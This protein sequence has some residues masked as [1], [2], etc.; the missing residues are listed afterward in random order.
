MVST[1]VRHQ[2]GRIWPTDPSNAAAEG[3]IATISNAFRTKPARILCASFNATG[4]LLVTL[5]THGVLVAFNLEQN[6][7]AVVSHAGSKCVAIAFSA[8]RRCELYVSQA[9]GAVACIDLT[10]KVTIGSMKGHIHPVRWLACHPSRPLLASTAADAL[11]VWNTRDFSRVRAMPTGRQAQLL[12]AVF[13]PLGEGLLTCAES[14]ITLWRLGSFEAALVLRVPTAQGAAFKLRTV[15][16]TADGALAAGACE[17]GWLALW[18][19]R[20]G[21]LAKMILLPDATATVRELTPLP[22]AHGSAAA[23]GSAPSRRGGHHASFVLTGEDGK[24]RVLDAAEPAIMQTLAPPAPSGRFLGAAID[25]A[26]KY[27]CAI[28]ADGALILYGM[29]ALLPTSS[30]GG[31]AG[32]QSSPQRLRSVSSGPLFHDNEKNDA[33]QQAAGP[34][35][36]RPLGARVAP[37]PLPSKLQAGWERQALE[38]QGRA[39]AEDSPLAS[40]CGV[41]IGSPLLD[42]RHLRTM[43]RT[44]WIF[45]APQRL[46]AWRFALQLPGN[47]GAHRALLAKGAHS[48][49]KQLVASL[50]LADRR[51]LRRLERLLS[52][53]AH[54]CPLLGLVRELPPAVY[55]L[56]LAFG[57]DDLA[58]FEASATVLLN[59]GA[60]FYEFHPHPPVEV[61]RDADRLLVIHA[62]AVHAHLAALGCGADVW[63]WPLLASLFSR[64]LAK[65]DW[66]QLWDHLLCNEPRFLLFVLVT[67]VALHGSLLCATASVASVAAVLVSRPAAMLM[68]VWLQTAYELHERTPDAGQPTKFPAFSPMPPGEMYP[69]GPPAPEAL[70]N[71]AATQLEAIRQS[72]LELARQRSLAAALEESDAAES[73]RLRDYHERHK[74]L[75]H[76]EAVSREELQSRRVDLEKQASKTAL[77]LKEQRLKGA[78]ARTERLRLAS[79]ARE[80]DHEQ[81]MHLL[82][83]QLAAV[84]AMAEVHLTTRAEELRLL[85]AEARHSEDVL[86]LQQ[87]AEAA[88]TRRAIEVAASSRA[89]YLALRERTDAEQAA[90]RLEA[91]ALRRDAEARRREVVLSSGADEARQLSV[92]SALRDAEMRRTMRAAELSRHAELEAVRQDEEA[93]TRHAS[94]VEAR[95]LRALTCHDDEASQALLAEQ[96]VWM[97]RRQAERTAVLDHEKRQAFSR[98]EGETNQLGELERQQRRVEAERR[99][100]EASALHLAAEAQHESSLGASLQ[101]L[102]VTSHVGAAPMHAQIAPTDQGWRAVA[103]EQ[104]DTM[105]RVDMGALQARER[106]IANVPDART[107]PYAHSLAPL[108]TTLAVPSSV[109]RAAVFAAAAALPTPA[110][111]ADEDVRS[112]IL[113]EALAAAARPPATEVAVA[114]APAAPPPARLTVVAALA[115]SATASSVAQSPGLPLRTGAAASVGASRQLETPAAPPALARDRAH[116]PSG[117]SGRGTASSREEEAAYASALPLLTN[118][119]LVPTT[120]ELRALEI[121]GC[122]PA[123]LSELRESSA[124]QVPALANPPADGRGFACDEMERGS[125]LDMHHPGTFSSTLDGV[126]ARRVSSL[127]SAGI[128]D[129]ALGGL[130]LSALEPGLA[131]RLRAQAREG[132]DS[133]LADEFGLG[134]GG[135]ERAS[136]IGLGSVGLSGESLRYS[137]DASDHAALVQELLG[138]PRAARQAEAAVDAFLSAQEADRGSSER[139]LS[140]GGAAAAALQ[141]SLAPS[142][143]STG[144]VHGGGLDSCAACS[145]IKQRYVEHD[146]WIASLKESAEAVLATHQRTRDALGGLLPETPGEK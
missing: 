101:H 114:N 46:Y 132:R 63:A 143:P 118:E 18:S 2:V 52:C 89:Q 146:E 33:P 92:E 139:A 138:N 12:H 3:I 45:P 108:L 84:E 57:G 38:R 103:N 35:E 69:A 50:P 9:D 6:R 76:A 40:Q 53:L 73:E 67:F 15:A 121:L 59:W 43:L 88:S 19:L 126:E 111:A 17:G 85:S 94:D 5:D 140:I 66:L 109:D 23:A 87:V 79:A 65:D 13:L 27:L 135:S 26:L 86:G 96:R 128:A 64:V 30:V 31:G 4:D 123:L 14:S 91:A 100:Q 36:A 102:Q 8:I 97:A 127:S 68:R 37:K 70:V 112:Q 7:F 11:I 55:P 41:R 77:A 99:L 71:H 10:T 110:G 61:L 81:T 117:G 62:P 60:C 137:A 95:R 83:E 115:P 93:V 119:E 44:C 116:A 42:P 82:H 34:T 48:A 29:R 58:A 78:D 49:V 113:H 120:A 28:S 21:I 130:R 72:E 47:E 51:G 124:A 142:Q 22:L 105:S 106:M 131:E 75:A 90:A 129:E 32:A 54:W 20:T 25:P 16:A 24:L 1:V 107:P 122:N 144:A 145:E 39:V 134:G 133:G 80:R 56:L 125:A 104:R 136:S 98:L 74:A 141:T